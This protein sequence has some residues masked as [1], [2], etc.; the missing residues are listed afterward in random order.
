MEVRW[1]FQSRVVQSVFECQENLMHCFE[2]IQC[3]SWDPITIREATG[4]LN[5]LRDDNFKFFLE[6]FNKIFYHV[7]ILYSIL[8][9]RNT[10]SILALESVD[11]FCKSINVIRNSLHLAECSQVVDSTQANRIRT[12]MHGLQLIGKE[13]CDIITTQVKTRFENFELIYAF[14]LVNPRE[15]CNYTKNFPLSNIKI[16][17]E[18]YPFFDH[19]ILKNELSVIYSNE[20]FQNMCSVV[21]LFS[22][23]KDN[24][25][26]ISFEQTTKLMEIVLVTPVTTAES[27]RCFSTLK[28]IK[29]YKSSTM[30]QNRLNSL[31]VLSICREIILHIPNFNEKVIDLFAQLKN[32]RADYLY[33]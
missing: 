26:C 11:V 16:V 4:L 21:E 15:F 23:F 10:N 31:A 28:N 17:T 13:I 22:F 27:E 25:L 12:S 8:Q 18:S 24:N 29:T 3:E 7:D 33:K 6:L 9:S 14:N 1:N 20:M 19:D 5:L 32:R 2:L 30:G